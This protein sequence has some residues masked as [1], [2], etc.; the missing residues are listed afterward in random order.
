MV[1]NEENAKTAKWVK[2]IANPE[3]GK[4]RFNYNVQELNYAD[5]R[6]SVVGVGASS[7]I[8]FKGE[9]KFWEVVE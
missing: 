3:W 5:G 7:A 4:K 1:L 6:C 9:Y 8:L 2:N